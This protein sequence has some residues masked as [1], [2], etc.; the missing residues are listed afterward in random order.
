MSCSRTQHNV[1]GEARTHGPS[2]WGQA[3][4]VRSSLAIIL[5][6]TQGGTLIFSNIRRRGPFQI[7]ELQYIFL[8]FQ[9]NEYSFGYDES[10]DIFGVITKLN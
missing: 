4:S 7:F 1:T 2:V 5:L 6:R 9:K 3:L 8:F 10:V